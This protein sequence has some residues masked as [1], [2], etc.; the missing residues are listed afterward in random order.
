MSQ[1]LRLAMIF[2]VFAVSALAMAVEPG[3]ASAKI[4]LSVST[5]KLKS[6]IDSAKGKTALELIESL[7]IWEKSLESTRNIE[8]ASQALMDRTRQA[9]K[10]FKAKAEKSA[11]EN[12]KIVQF[13]KEKSSQLGE[14]ADTLDES[15]SDLRKTMDELKKRIKEIQ[16]DPDAKAILD[17]Q[18]LMNEADAA[19]GKAESI[20]IP[21]NLNAK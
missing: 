20:R 9:Q 18:R 17:A 1:L 21:G 11:G 4:D 10:D 3:P 8:A 13:Y 15:L 7:P 5:A 14:Q 19:M 16:S 6:S 2:T 12:P